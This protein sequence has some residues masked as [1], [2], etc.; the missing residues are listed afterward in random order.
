MLIAERARPSGLALFYR[1]ENLESQVH[2]QVWLQ[3]SGYGRQ[4]LFDAE[5]VEVRNFK[6][7]IAASIDA[8]KGFE[9]H[10]DV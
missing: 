9:I 3:L 6:V 5:R 2:E 10:V 4:R 1:Y 8:R 7:R